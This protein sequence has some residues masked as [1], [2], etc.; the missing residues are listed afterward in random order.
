MVKRLRLKI[1]DLENL[2]LYSN[3]KC[4]VKNLAQKCFDSINKSE[5]DIRKDLYQCI[6]LSGGTT[7]FS[8]LSERITKEVKNLVPESMKNNIKVIA[9]PKRNYSA[10][11]GVS[12][13]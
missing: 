8:G 4:V 3:Q 1:K 2:K 6:V 11:I 12:I 5:I 7:M 10:W 13:L 9:N